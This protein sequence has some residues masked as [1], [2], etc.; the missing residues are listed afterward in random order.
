MEN[1]GLR[2]LIKDDKY[3]DLN[4]MYNLFGKV[5]N[6]RE[7]LIKALCDY[8]KELGEDIN[9]TWALVSSKNES[10]KSINH[11]VNNHNSNN[12]NNSI[13]NNNSKT[14]DTVENTN[15]KKENSTK[16]SVN[17]KQWVV[18]YLELKDKL[19][20][21]L[22]KAFDNDKNFQMKMNSI[23]QLI[24]NENPKASESLSLFIDDNLKK[25]IKGVNILVSYILNIQRIM[26]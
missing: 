1:S 6:G 26:F 21:I 12:S 4:R 5:N 8:I 15:S 2:S 17:P 16:Q 25:G 13:N 14:L 7:E 22:I 9:E 10:N 11:I 20:N 23:F 19:D 24:I 18:K 3:S